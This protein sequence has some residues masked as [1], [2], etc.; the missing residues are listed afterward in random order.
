MKNLQ[1][2]EISQLMQ[3]SQV[4]AE[5][6]FYQKL[7]ASGVLAIY[8][9]AVELGLPVMY[10]LNG[11]LYNVEGKVTLSANA[12][13]M[14]LANAG[15]KIQ[16]IEMTDEACHL[17]FISPHGKSINEFRYTI[18]DA[19]NAGYLGVQGLQGTWEKKPKQNWIYFKKDMLFNR[20]IASGGR[21]FAP[22]VIGNLY[23]EGEIGGEDLIIPIEN[24]IIQNQPE[25]KVRENLLNHSKGLDDVDEFKK[26]HK[27]F[28]GERI[29]DYVIQ[30]ANKKKIPEDQA[31]TQCFLNEKAFID[32]FNEFEK[33]QNKI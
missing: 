26:R 32:S 15:W 22:A 19:K 16:F 4:L 25:K 30:V 28:K 5:S 1:L 13:N 18:E 9:T 17:K 6:P 7:G 29:Y 3:V 12:I 10:C 24:S 2:A 20:C 23:I 21:K 31:M 33:I 11:G 27:I 8:L 14:M